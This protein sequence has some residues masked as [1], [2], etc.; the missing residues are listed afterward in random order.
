MGG[1]YYLP[2]PKS[3]EPTVKINAIKLNRSKKLEGKSGFYDGKPVTSRFK[4]IGELAEI[5]AEAAESN[6]QV[7]DIYG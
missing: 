6:N 4:L 3:S 1:C 7:I 2:M 5:A